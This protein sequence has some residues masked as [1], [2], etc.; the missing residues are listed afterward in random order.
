MLK[1]LDPT[2]LVQF[3]QAGTQSH[4]D[5]YC[6]MY[7]RMDKV[8]NYVTSN[9]VY[10]PLILCEYVHAMG[11]SLGNFQDYWDL[12]EQYPLLQG[13]F[14]WDWVD[15]SVVN[16]RDG[17]R[18][19]DY[20]GAFGYQDQRNDHAFCMNGLINGDR[21]YNPHAYEAKKGFK[22]LE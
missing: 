7:M 22:V 15:Q 20:G 16:Y 10:R 4:T 21:E 12:F 9:D 19:L 2:S 18:F 3:E 17:A 14:I 13:G 6:P 11:N 1:K 5:V 8:K